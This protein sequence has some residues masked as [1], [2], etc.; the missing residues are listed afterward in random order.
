MQWDGHILEKV[1]AANS[2]YAFR[3]TPCTVAQQVKVDLIRHHAP[4]VYKCQCLLMTCAESLC[5][6]TLA[7]ALR[8]VSD[9]HLTPDDAQPARA[10][11]PGPSTSSSIGRW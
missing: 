7:A 6:A 5:P 2:E 3:N 4:R 11:V 10:A 1:Q 8:A 9:F